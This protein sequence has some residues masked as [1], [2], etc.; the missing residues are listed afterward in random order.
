MISITTNIKALNA[1]IK[2]VVDAK[3]TKALMRP[4]VNDVM[5]MMEER[6]HEDGK[7]ADGSSLGTYSER[8]L[9]FRKAN[10]RGGS[11]AKKMTFTRQLQ[12]SYNIAP[13][14]VGWSIVI[15]VNGRNPTSNYLNKKN[16]AAKSASASKV[17][18]T[19]SEIVKYQEESTGK[20]IWKLSAEE[21]KYFKTELTNIFKLKL[22]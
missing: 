18:V 17:S 20:K 16:K 1:A 10:G 21:R 6:I 2:R 15:A 12:G 14:E 4:V 11:A 22:R 5:S 19:N 7:A 3:D 9:A 13:S 8:Y